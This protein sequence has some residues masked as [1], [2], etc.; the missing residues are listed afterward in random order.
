MRM[1]T[2]FYSW[3]RS[4]RNWQSAMGTS[5]GSYEKLRPSLPKP[6]WWC[7]RQTSYLRKPCEGSRIRIEGKRKWYLSPKIA[8]IICFPYADQIPQQPKSIVKL[9]PLQNPSPNFTNQRR[10]LKRST[11]CTI[12]SP[13]AVRRTK[14]GLLVPWPVAL[15]ALQQSTSHTS[16]SSL[17]MWKAVVAITVTAEPNLSLFRTSN[18]STIC[19]RKWPQL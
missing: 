12:C 1:I 7:Q 18:Q 13:V 14:L 16:Q 15:E 6:R 5:E 11:S 8:L 4:W 3:F 19:R 17:A 2:S 9:L 10:G